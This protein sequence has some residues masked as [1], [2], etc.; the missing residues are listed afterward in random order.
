MKPGGNSERHIA[1][2]EDVAQPPGPAGGGAS[3]VPRAGKCLFEQCRKVIAPPWAVVG[4][5]QSPDVGVG[6]HVAQFVGLVSRI[7]QYRHAAR[8]RRPDQQLTE[9][10]PVGKQQA[11][12]V[13]RGETKGPQRGGVAQRS[14]VQV[15]IAEALVGEHDRLAV[16]GPRRRRAQDLA[17]VGRSG[18]R[19][20]G[21]KSAG[22]H[23]SVRTSS[24][25]G[26]WRRGRQSGRVDI[27]SPPRPSALVFASVL[28]AT[29]EMA[30]RLD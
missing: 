22:I 23:R 24:L 5:N 19:S 12:M 26:G 8:H 2:D 20:E 3:P 9:L 21:R 10:R 7:D 16:T 11:D 15:G 13:S 1:E 4:A 30:A 14:R 18:R 27:R 6:D 17:D 25:K 29:A 28:R